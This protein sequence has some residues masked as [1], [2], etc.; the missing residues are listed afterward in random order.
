[1]SESVEKTT[2]AL[3]NNA[4]AIDDVAELLD[5]FKQR[6]EGF[7]LKVVE[8]IVRAQDTAASIGSDHLHIMKA[9]YIPT[10]PLSKLRSK[11]VLFDPSEVAAEYAAILERDGIADVAVIMKRLVPLVAVGDHEF[12]VRSVFPEIERIAREKAYDVGVTS[13]ITSLPSLRI[14]LNE[15]IFALDGGES[16]QM[17]SKIDLYILTSIS[18]FD[19]AYSST[20]EVEV[21]TGPEVK[22]LRNGPKPEVNLYRRSFKKVPNRHRVCHALPDDNGDAIAYDH[23]HAVNALSLLYVMGRIGAIF[24]DSGYRV[25]ATA[26]NKKASLDHWRQARYDL[27]R[28]IGRMWRLVGGQVPKSSGVEAPSTVTATRVSVKELMAR[29][30]PRPSPRMIRKPSS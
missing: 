14:A 28:S 1:M 26:H 19:F 20:D 17:Y 23:V 16:R 30:P 6:F 3:T 18:A 21:D 27:S 5:V 25:P 24:S 10:M 12:S 22:G 11:T 7:V 9:G 2:N 15:A 4:L 8:G 29:V 13:Q